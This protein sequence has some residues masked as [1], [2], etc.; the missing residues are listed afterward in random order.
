MW[1][2]LK[3]YLKLKLSVLPAIGRLF[4]TQGVTTQNPGT[5]LHTLKGGAVAPSHANPYDR[6]LTTRNARR[7]ATKAAR[8]KGRV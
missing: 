5:V 2:S 3:Q 6:P 7:L 8:R 1:P 4:H